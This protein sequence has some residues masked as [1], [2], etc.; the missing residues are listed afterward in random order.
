VIG[1]DRSDTLC[2]SDRVYILIG[3]SYKPVAPSIAEEMAD[4]M[5]LIS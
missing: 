2:L 1:R 5:F 4:L 3:R